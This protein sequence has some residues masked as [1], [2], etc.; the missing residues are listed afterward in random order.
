MPKHTPGRGAAQRRSQSVT[1]MPWNRLG[2]DLAGHL[3]AIDA[4]TDA[5]IAP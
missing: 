5:L 2:S 3:A 1:R 4:L